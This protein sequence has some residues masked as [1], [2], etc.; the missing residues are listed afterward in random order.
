MRGQAWKKQPELY[1][2]FYNGHE[3]PWL[4]QQDWERE[5]TNFY[6]AELVPWYQ[7]HYRNIESFLRDGD[8]TVIG[9]EGNSRLDVNWKSSEYSVSVSGVDVARD[10][11]TFCP[12]GKDRVAFYSR[13]AKEL[14][15]PLPDGWDASAVVARTMSADA[16][17]PATVSVRDGKLIV[18][19][20]AERPVMVFRDAAAAR[21]QK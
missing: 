6:Y 4:P 3:F 21:F 2:L 17:E 19:V 7:V 11:D 14:S 8:R 13:T 5:F 12:I 15:A 16:A 10:G 1:S 20:Q 18:N 9:L